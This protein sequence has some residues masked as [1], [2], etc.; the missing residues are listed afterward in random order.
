MSFRRS[1]GDSGLFIGLG[2]CNQKTLPPTLVT[3]TRRQIVTCHMCGHRVGT[4]PTFSPIMKSNLQTHIYFCYFHLFSQPWTLHFHTQNHKNF[5][6]VTISAKASQLQQFQTPLAPPKSISPL[7]VFSS[8][9]NP[10]LAVSNR[11]CCGTGA[12]VASSGSGGVDSINAKLSS[13]PGN[14]TFW[15][16]KKKGRHKRVAPENIE[17]LVEHIFN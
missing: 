12:S 14:W 2:N 10:L 3:A 17:M 7:L 9:E 6:W 8:F 5:C 1:L 16:C 11:P 4:P 13:S 15:T